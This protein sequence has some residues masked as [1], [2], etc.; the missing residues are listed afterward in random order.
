M[1]KIRL[2]KVARELN[3]AL[4]TCIEF[5]RAKK[6]EIDDNPN[7]RIEETIAEILYKE[8]GIYL[9]KRLLLNSLIQ[10]KRDAGKFYKG[11]PIKELWED[12][13]V[14]YGLQDK[15]VETIALTPETLR[16]INHL[17][18][19][20]VVNVTI[21]RFEK[22]FIRVLVNDRKGIIY[23][24]DISI[25]KK[26]NPLQMHVGE[27]F[28]AKIIAIYDEA[29]IL[30]QKAIYG[31]MELSQTKE[32]VYI[33]DTNIFLSRPDILAI[34]TDQY[35]V[36]IPNTVITEL[37]FRKSDQNVSIAASARKSL[38]YINEALAIPNNVRSEQSDRNFCPIDSDY[39][40][41]DDKILAIAMKETQRGFNPIIMTNDVGLQAKAKANK[42]TNISLDDFLNQG[43]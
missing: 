1:G 5:L 28:Q 14:D 30:S 22:D 27:T 12:A 42:V 26:P 15:R 32:N 20:A 9:E 29:I 3:V 7:V 2:C 38:K 21:E 24:K 25:N 36:L 39:R 8:F 11:E 18:K 43:V 6:I 33:I 4:P 31:R 23:K 13:T 41:N 19:F 37:D 40:S 34:I 10:A 16:N 35:Q 17:K